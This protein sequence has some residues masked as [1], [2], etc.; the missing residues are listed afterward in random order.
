MP[1]IFNDVL[2]PV[3]RGPSSSHTAGS[4]RIGLL[5]R[6]LA[7][8]DFKSAAFEFHP[9]GSLA[10]TH[11]TQGSD[12]G[13]ATGL[14][15][16]DI[17]DPEM[18]DALEIAKNS[19]I[20]IS[21]HITDYPANHPNTYKCTLTDVKGD[22]VTAVAIST[23]GGMIKMIDLMG[24]PVD[25]PGDDT[26]FFAI[27]KDA[28]DCLIRKQ[29]EDL[30]TGIQGYAGS[31]WTTDG[32]RNAVI[33][34]FSSSPDLKEHNHIFAS[35]FQFYRLLRSV[36]PIPG[37]T[38]SSLPFSNLAELLK[39]SDLMAFTASELAR[40]YE[41]V[42]SGYA[43]VELDRMM[44]NLI[45]IWR[46]G[47]QIGLDETRYKDRLVGSQSPGFMLHFRSGHLIDA[48][49]LN[50][51]IAYSTALMEVKS[52]MGVVIAA[53]TAGACG[54][55]PGC[56]IG[57]ADY[58]NN[59]EPLLRGFWAAGLVGLFIAM[60]ATF[61]AEVAGCQAET[62]AGA[63][64]AAAGLVEMTGGTAQQAFDAASIALQNVMGLV[65]DPIAN[66]VEIPCLS[67]NANAAGNALTSANM[68]LGGIQ[69]IIPLNETI[70]TMMK[71]GQA[72]PASLRCTALGGLSDT[73][74][75]RM[76]EA[77]IND[78]NYIKKSKN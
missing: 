69:A 52:S 19:G 26:V 61:A 23:G 13:L 77:A 9:E 51:M 32:S 50:N 62:G 27:Y 78:I 41:S 37:Q 8:H 75:A 20:D 12:L 72:M 31:E 57:L 48:G 71:V 4:Y 5:L 67:R 34:R 11:Q 53:P 33:Y 66:R 35:C 17:L 74:T 29:I 39:R 15:G 44:E 21:F 46:N 36:M 63:A 60:D 56:L 2:G 18:I 7:G 45:A 10:T 24:F 40:M 22:Q 64:M 68:V 73:P 25:L 55:L 58:H 16:M 47:I 42:R 38:S 1:S 70:T 30:M 28:S 14:I 49:P 3:M 65:C 43:M 6:D 76:M 54:G 59:H